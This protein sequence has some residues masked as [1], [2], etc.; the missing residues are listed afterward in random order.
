MLERRKPT[1]LSL[2]ESDDVLNR[3]RALVE[4]GAWSIIAA[5]AGFPHN[6]SEPGSQGAGISWYYKDDAE[7]IELS[8]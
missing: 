8:E 6:G 7:W 4:S 2:E 1:I 5:A 3:A